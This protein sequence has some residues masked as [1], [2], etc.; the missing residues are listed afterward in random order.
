MDR[1]VIELIS[2]V[3]VWLSLISAAGMYFGAFFNSTELILGFG[4]AC[5]LLGSALG[6][7][8]AV[9]GHWATASIIGAIVCL[10]TIYLVYLYRLEH[11]PRKWPSDY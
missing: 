2:Q 4:T 8:E 9:Q 1:Q 7:F 10:T 11:A 6:V 3:L 5:A